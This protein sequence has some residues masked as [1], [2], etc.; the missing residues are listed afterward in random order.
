MPFAFEV[1]ARATDERGH[2]MRARDYSQRRSNW[3]DEG[4]NS[5]NLLS[6]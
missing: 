3:K 1:A 2:A 5:D 6:S 4:Y